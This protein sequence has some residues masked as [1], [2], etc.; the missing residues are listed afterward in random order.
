VTRLVDSF[1]ARRPSPLLFRALRVL[2][3]ARAWTAPNIWNP[4]QL[5]EEEG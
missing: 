5:L 4:D 1:E 3:T 2:F